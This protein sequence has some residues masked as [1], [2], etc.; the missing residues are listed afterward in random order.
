M[1]KLTHVLALVGGAVAAF[2]TSPAGLAVAHQ[3]PIL[4]PVFSFVGVVLAVYHSP[5]AT[6]KS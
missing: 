3:Y 1:T 5:K 2:I 4:V 6:A